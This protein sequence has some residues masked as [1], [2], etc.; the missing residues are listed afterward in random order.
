MNTA[1]FVLLLMIPA[2][3]ACGSKWDFEDGDGDGVSA[4]E[5][6]CWDKEEGPPGLGLK[7]SDIFPGAE[8]TWYDGFDQNCAGDDD[9]DADADGYIQEEY[10]G[11]GTQ[12]LPETGFLPPGDCWDAAEGPGDGLIAGADINPAAADV[13]Y[14]GV[15]QDCAGDDDFDKDGDPDI[16]IGN[17]PK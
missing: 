6:D 5:G 16:F 1:R 8:E 7:G 13:W 14:D 11:L 10:V 3:T 15:D 9:Y 4:A 12:G 17:E 2:V